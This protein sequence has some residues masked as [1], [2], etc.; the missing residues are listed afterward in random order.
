M[1]FRSH[2]PLLS[3]LMGVSSIAAAAILIMPGAGHADTNAHITPCRAAAERHFEWGRIIVREVNNRDFDWDADITPTK[4]VDPHYTEID[5][6]GTQTDVRKAFEGIA[7]EVAAHPGST[8]K[9]PISIAYC[10]Q[11]S[12]KVVL[13]V[14]KGESVITYAD[15][16]V[17]RQIFTT[18]NI[19]EMKSGVWSLTHHHRDIIPPNSVVVMQH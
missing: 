5:T 4:I 19:F 10:R 18:S 1:L 7:S 2:A 8:W 6:D 14:P 17:S 16:T 11:L 15:G 13:I 9:F 3:T 12:E